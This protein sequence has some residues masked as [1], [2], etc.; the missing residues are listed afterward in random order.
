MGFFFRKSN[1][2]ITIDKLKRQLDQSKDK[3]AFYLLSI[4][5]MLHLLKEFA[6]DESEIDVDEFKKQINLLNEKF[7]KEH[8]TKPISSLLKKTEENT[9]KFIS[10]QKD[11]IKERDA[12]LRDIIDIMSKALA[13]Q[14]DENR[15]Y[16]KNIYTHSEKIE[17]LTLLDDLRK[18]RSALENE[19][20]ELRRNVRDKQT[21]EENRMKS[22]SQKVAALNNEL[23]KVKK[24]AMMDALT[25]IYNRKA[26]DR[27]I[28]DLSRKNTP[29]NTSF[30]LLMI[31]IDD[32]KKINDAYGHQTGD[33][34]LVSMAGKCK[35]IIRSD[36]FLCRYGGEEFVLILPALSL[37]NGIKKARQICK[38]V[39]KA[40][41]K[42]TLDGVDT[43]ITLRITVSIGVSVYRKSD[44]PA[45][46]LERADKALYRAKGTGKN[47]V[48][49]EKD[50]R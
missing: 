30:A 40:Q 17:R 11:Y 3:Q 36:D 28:A 19:V 39:E 16:H 5:T 27:Y 43:G 15:K 25:G 44:T 10:N 8:E 18:I 7:E 26:F 23:R 38:A 41:F 45:T 32:F 35:E 13:A 50:I 33:R 48:V 37:K 2:K 24:E 6:L 21:L 49:S 31:D 14:N 34:V 20:A 1:K 22:M 29:R 47:R 42:H 9:L 4:R 46:V 12:E